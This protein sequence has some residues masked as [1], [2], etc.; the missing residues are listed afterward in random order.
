MKLP[1]YPWYPDDYL[2]SPWVMTCDLADE[3][4]YRRL[5]DQQ[6]KHPGCQIQNDPAYIR[7]LCKGAKWIKIEAVLKANFELIEVQKDVFFWRNS[8]IYSEFCKALLK[9]E[10]ACESV[11]HTERYKKKQSND[12]RTII[13]RLS[14]QNQNQNQ[15]QIKEEAVGE[16][17]LQPSPEKPKKSS[18]RKKS[19]MTDEEWLA[20]VKAN[21]AYSGL[22]VDRVQ[23][24]L[25]AW[26]AT[27]GK[28]PTRSRLLNWLNR[29]E[30]PLTGGNGN[31]SG[32]NGDQK[33]NGR[34]RQTGAGIK[35]QPG[36][37]D[38]IKPIM[39]IGDD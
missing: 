13:E 17:P 5:L 36:E 37:Y 15:N 23:A 20:M 38:N 34:I 28:E 12:N 16:M 33:S 24:K 14:N 4:I 31:G 19:E 11:K 18:R 35:P 8:R 21:P 3:G 25:L 7:K 22:D 29:E 39:V 6:W 32:G 2:S 27:K 1:H 9:H 10:K 30:K 26:C